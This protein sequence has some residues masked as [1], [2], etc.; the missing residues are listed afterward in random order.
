MLSCSVVLSMID[1]NDDV[2]NHLH[3][4]CAEDIHTYMH[5]SFLRVVPRCVR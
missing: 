1:D 3:K 5:I 4:K 2:L